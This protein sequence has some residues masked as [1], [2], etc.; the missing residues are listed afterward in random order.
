[1]IAAVSS[2]DFRLPSVALALAGAMFFPA[3]HAEI[4]GVE[5]VGTQSAPVGCDV[6]SM[7]ALPDVRYES[8]KREPLPVAHCKVAGVIG[9]ETHFELLLPADW[10]GKFVFGGGGGFVG[11]VINT[12]LGFGV[13]QKG[14]ATV[15]TDTGHRGSAIDASW[16]LNNLERVVSFG[17]QAVHRTAVTAGALIAE[18]YGRDS[19]RNLF[20]GC[21]RGGGQALMEAQRYPDDFDGIVAG[22]P[23]NNWTEELG[24]R[25]TWI[26]Q[27]MYPNPE[28]LGVAAIS[29]QVLEFMGNAVI[30]QCD[31]L[32]GLTDGVLNDPL[33]CDFDVSQLGCEAAAASSNSC[34]SLAQLQAAQ[35]A[36]GGF[37]LNGEQVVP[38]YPPGAELG[39][40]GWERWIAGGFDVVD[41][42]EFQRGVEPDPD[43]P[44]PDTPSAHFAFGNNV[45][46][47]LVFH[48]PDWDYSTYDFSTFRSDVAAV[49]STLDATDP[50]LDAF[51]ARG[52]KLL[53]FNGWRDMALTPLGTIEYY[54]AVMQRDETA[55]EDVRLIMVPG[56]DHCFGGPGPSLVNWVDE[57]DKWVDTDQAPDQVT[58]Y[59]VD[60]QMQLSG[61]RLACA[62][63]SVLRYDGSGDPRDAGSFNC[64]RPD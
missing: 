19:S 26:N 34:L 32:D 4:E 18:H 25:N 15:G 36:Y 14:Y 1:M 39:A 35:R 49:A 56:M 55:A 42:D 63:P 22:A 60:E 23:A 64:V 24:G 10:N 11:S 62:W 40:G 53:L 21:S 5:G 20:F 28:D 41:I 17:H 54:E 3:S 27:A 37:V 52:G 38:G 48:D 47:Y 46:K 59:F 9:T 44:D 12:A 7:P 13:L 6:E 2:L 8:V 31:A 43:H 16:A 57:I 61:S 50:N 30:Q 33:A 51:R 45:M 29:P 58:A